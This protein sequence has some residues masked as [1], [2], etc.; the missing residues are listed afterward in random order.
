MIRLL[1]PVDVMRKLFQLEESHHTFYLTGS[2]YFRTHRQDSDYD[3]FAQDTPALR[4]FLDSAG[5][6][7]H[8]PLD[9]EW[10]DTYS[11]DPNIAHVMRWKFGFPHIDVQL[12]KDLELKRRAQ[13]MIDALGL[14]RR[15][16]PKDEARRIWRSITVHMEGWK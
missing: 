16:I 6:R 1:S 3:F 5:F 4:S 8:N 7:P 15:E 11:L 9:D 13:G 12:V 14:L 2:R 10:M